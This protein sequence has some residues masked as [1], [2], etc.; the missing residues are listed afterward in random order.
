MS[1]KKTRTK[2]SKDFID[3]RAHLKNTHTAH[4]VH[5][6][7]ELITILELDKRSLEVVLLEQEIQKLA[8]E[9]IRGRLRNAENTL[10]YIICIR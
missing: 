1:D 10:F 8:D 4:V 5:K 9:N 6:Q 3:N 2:L 7:N